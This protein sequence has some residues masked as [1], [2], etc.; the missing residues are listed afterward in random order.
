MPG[1]PVYGT[2]RR[3]ARI[4]DRPAAVDPYPEETSM[5]LWE[6]HQFDAL[7]LTGA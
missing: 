3:L 2:E 5:R 6:R 1:W 7:G 4:Y